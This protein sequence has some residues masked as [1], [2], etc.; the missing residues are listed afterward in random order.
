MQKKDAK[1]RLLRWIL[2]LQ[3]FDIEIKDKRGVENGVADHLSWIQIEDDVP[4][5]NF[6][7]TKNV[8]QTDSLVGKICLTFEEPFFDADDAMSIDTPDDQDQET[9]PITITFNIKISVACNKLHPE[10]DA[11]VDGSL[12]REVHGVKRSLRDRPWY[13]DIVDYLAADVEPEELRRSP[14]K[15]FL[16]EVR[17]YHWNEPY[18]YKH[19]SDGIYRRCV[20][21]T[22]IPDILFQCHGSDYAGHFATLKTVSKI[23][24]AGFWWPIMFRDCGNR[25]SH[26]RL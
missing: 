11:P 25:N 5:D 7:P 24:Q 6:L 2:L 4:I 20:A 13:A 26:R 15:K 16:R 19:C 9:S 12:S 17:I 1:P 23:L 21:E 10:H 22:E 3:G 14:R 18:L 8:Y